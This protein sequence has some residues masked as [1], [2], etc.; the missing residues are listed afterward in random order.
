MRPE[1]VTPRRVLGDLKH[2]QQLAKLVM[3][4][5]HGFQELLSVP[6]DTKSIGQGAAAA[7]A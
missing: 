6:V 2:R 7:A 3:K 5:A 4:T 1:F